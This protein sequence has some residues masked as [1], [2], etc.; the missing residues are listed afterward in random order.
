MRTLQVFEARGINL[1]RVES[2]PIPGRPWEYLFFV[3]MVGTLDD[4]LIDALGALTTRLDVLGRF[5]EA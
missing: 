4:E 1:T 5:K 2:R 3:D